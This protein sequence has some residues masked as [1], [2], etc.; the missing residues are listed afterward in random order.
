MAY[1]QLA[2][3]IVDLVGGKDNVNSVVH[4][5][6]RLRFKLRDEKKAQDEALKNHDGVVTVVKSGGQY[7]VVIGNQVADVYN[8][9]IKAGGFHDGGSVPDDDVED[10][11]SMNPLDKFID[12]V[13]SI[14]TPALGLLAAT[15]MIK[16]FNAMFSSLGWI[17][18][19]S[20]SYIILNAIGDSFFYFLPILLGYSA[21]KKFKLNPFIGMALGA[22]LVYPSLIAMVP[23]NVAAGV[24]PVMTLFKGTMIESPVYMKFFG[25]PVIMMNYTSSVIPIIVSTWIAAK[26]EHFL[27]R[28]LPDVVK[29]FLVPFFVMLVIVPLTL[30][31]VGPIASWISDAISA[32]VVGLYNMQPILA[33]VLL[34]GLWQVLVIF[35]LHWGLVPIAM[36]NIQNLHYDTILALIVGA[37]FAQIGAVLAVTLTSKDAKFKGLGWSAFISGIFGVTEPA[38]YGITLPRKKP[39]IMSCIGAG[40]AGGILGAFGSKMFMMGGMGIFQFPAMIGPKGMDMSFYGVLIA[41][42]VGFALTFVLTMLFAREK[43]DQVALAPAGA[44]V[45][46]PVADASAESTTATTISNES[47]TAPVDG[48]LIPLSEVKDEVFASEAMGKGVA[49]E[50]TDGHI[51]AP[52][53]GTISL[54]FPSKHAIGMHTDHGADIL[55]HVGMDTVQLGGKHFESNVDQG[56]VVKQG[57]L[58]MT[59]DLDAIKSDGYA[60]TTPVIIT[61]TGDY[62]TIAAAEPDSV[63]HWNQIL[64]LEK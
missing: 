57:D 54:V 10:T 49:I 34:G 40:V 38:I 2:K 50:P 23:A 16:G 22:A 61:N 20:G 18:A 25:I 60:V 59:F 1:E 53:D 52:A 35:G 15:G 44:A 33:G 51:Y 28:I 62:T 21:A 45:A 37:S 8:E 26:F 41:C 31:V 4:C 9:V 17:S 32:G 27:K 12:M 42:A 24:H 5:T 43:N 29:M 19:T 3:D 47:L 48:Q 11:S 63:T 14:F 56:A 6:T 58:L 46:A 55:I 39:F 7:Q 64:Q 13:S 30:I 36:L